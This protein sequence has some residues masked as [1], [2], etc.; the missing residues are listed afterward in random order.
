MDLILL[1]HTASLDN[2]A[3]V[4]S[5]PQVDLSEKGYQQLQMLLKKD[6][7]VEKIY[8]SPYKRSRLLA[9]A[10][11]EKLGLSLEIDDRLREIGFGD[12]E[13]KTFEE[14]EELYPKE[15]EAWMADPWGFKYPGG[16]AFSSVRQRAADFVKEL[17]K[18]SLVISHQALMFSLMAEV[19]AYDYEQLSKLYL[20]SG[21]QVHLKSQPWRLVKLE[22]I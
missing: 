6:F 9:E 7:Q 2:E 16:E 13:G 20:G 3:G 19:L 10:L 8:S 11:A 5:H 21:A 12:F 17:Y 1:R 15:V 4:F 18:S 14:I 22:N